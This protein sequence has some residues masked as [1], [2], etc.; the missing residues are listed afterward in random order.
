MFDIDGGFIL[1]YGGIE[2]NLS[3]DAIFEEKKDQM[4]DLAGKILFS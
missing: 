4:Q 3:V 2:Q 1:K